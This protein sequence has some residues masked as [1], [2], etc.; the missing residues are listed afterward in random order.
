MSVWNDR[1]CWASTMWL[2]LDTTAAV[3]GLN[4]DTIDD[5]VARNDSEFPRPNPERRGVYFSAE[6]VFRYILKHRGQAHDVVPRLFPRVS[7]PPPARFMHAKTA[8]LR[9]VGSFAVH[10]WQ[11]GDDGR[12]IAIAYPDR[13]NSIHINNVGAATAALLEQLSPQVEAVAVPDGGASRSL[14]IPGTP[15]NEPTI[16]VAERNPVYRRYPTS[17]GTAH[18]V[19]SDLANLLRVDI[20]WWSFLLRDLDAMLAWQPGTP[21]TPVAPYVPDFD[22]SHIRALAGANDSATLRAAIDTLINRVVTR[23]NGNTRDDGNRLTPGLT[24]AAF[25]TVDPTQPLPELTAGQAAVILH[26][27]AQSHAAKQALRVA[28]HWAFLPILTYVIEINRTSAGPMARQW[29]SRLA[30]VAEDRRSELGFWFVSRYL[31]SGVRPVRWLTDPDNPTSWI[32]QGDN[33]VIYAGVGTRTSGA[34]G[35]LVDA[36]MDSAAGFFHD[37]AGQIWP[38]PDTGFDYYGTGYS[39]GGPQRLAETLTTLTDDATADVHTPPEL[40]TDNIGLYRALYRLVTEHRAP[41]SIPAELIA[42]HLPGSR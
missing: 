27:R 14:I 3:T 12:P 2:D 13:E 36:E 35:Q 42:A 31:S 38:L 18:Y 34:N 23:L 15:E 30:D 1:S 11:P 37:G 29:V 20:P 7:E 16:V 10:T 25:S 41:I 33:A 24:Q 28:D 39:G 19:W 32:L 4:A 9:D 21:A 8:T 5:Y 26:H 40:T 17:D 22:T 6:H